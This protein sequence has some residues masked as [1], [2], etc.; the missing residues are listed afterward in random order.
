MLCQRS[1]NPSWVDGRRWSG[2]SIMKVSAQRAVIA[3]VSTDTFMIYKEQPWVGRGSVGRIAAGP[4]SV[5]GSSGDMLVPVVDEVAQVGVGTAPG[6]RRQW[7]TNSKSSP[8]RPAGSR[9]RRGRRC[10]HRAPRPGSESGTRRPLRS[11]ES[12]PV[13]QRDQ[14]QAGCERQG[15]LRLVHH[16][17]AG[18][19][20]TSS[21]I[22]SG[23][24]RRGC[25][26][27]CPQ[28]SSRERRRR[29]WHGHRPRK[30]QVII[31]VSVETVAIATTSTDAFMI[32]AFPPTN[33]RL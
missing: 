8:A 33:Q 32:T 12:E 23:N 9:G 18:R 16:V 5:A 22:R 13:H 15:G 10:Q 20:E 25:A 31:N 29:F 3:T 24:P 21:G 19:V 1:T 14:V 6:N 4:A 26:G 30:C 17:E 28:P 11:A 27:W 2:H 7:S